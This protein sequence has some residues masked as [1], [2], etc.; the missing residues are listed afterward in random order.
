MDLIREGVRLLSLDECAKAV[1][2]FEK[3]LERAPDHPDAHHLIAVSCLRSG[4]DLDRAERHVSRA[5]QLRP[6]EAVFKNTQGSLLSAQEKHREAL[7][8]FQQ[9]LETNPDYLDALFNCAHV[10]RVLGQNVA[11]LALF[12]RILEKV[13][14]HAE[15][16]NASGVIFVESGR[17]GLARD[18]FLAA[19]EQDPLRPEYYL[20]LANAL[21]ALGDTDEAISNAQTALALAPTSAEALN[22]LGS[23]Y[24]EQGSLEDARHCFERSLELDETSLRALYNL[25]VC[26]HEIGEHVKSVEIYDRFL[27]QYPAVTN[28]ALNRANALFKL[29]RYDEALRQ[30][31]EVLDQAPGHHAA[32]MGLG[33]GYRRLGELA[34]ASD[35]YAAA[36]RTQPAS[37]AA[38]FA[39]SLVLLKQ[40]DFIRGWRHYEWRFA[41]NDKPQGQF[42]QLQTPDWSGEPLEGKSILVVGEQGLGDIVHF[43]RYLKQLKAMGAKVIMVSAP[44]L[45][46][47]VATMNCVDE[48][49]PRTGPWYM[50]GDYHVYLLSLPFKLRTTLDTIPAE[51]PYFIVDED[52]VQYWRARL[53]PGRMN[54]GIAWSGNPK[55]AENESRSC[56]LTVLKPISDLAGV[57]VYSLQKNH[58]A[59]Q[60]RDHAAS[61]DII[62]YTDEFATYYDTASFM[63][64]LDLV[65]TVDTS[66]AHVAGAINARVWT[67]LWFAHCWRYLRHR[68]DSPWYPSMR[69]FRQRRVGDWAGVVDDVL[70]ALQ[71][72]LD[73]AQPV[74]GAVS[75][76]TGARE[77]S[78]RR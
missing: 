16:L 74:E 38:H 71:L 78:G 19:L 54:I 3:V 28:A 70:A 21:Q 33:H 26:Y 29:G 5:L 27:A 41:S 11:A 65:I 37:S 52:R 48:V 57:Q 53:D 43:C 34:R 6:G 50:Q 60:L 62:D 15:S 23:F 42:L 8:C 39:L 20:N 45:D 1:D 25:G 73:Q 24:L 72:E 13:P 58:G 66:V 40:G 47:L 77:E 22:N 64:A 69:L 61:Y 56:P 75:L 59:E 36:I 7:A 4:V 35:Y 55:Q 76:I 68:T 63:K 46:E 12:D 67:I 32:L 30:F 18:R 31:D 49:I 14:D 2:C 17:P 9:A 10:S 44:E 51:C